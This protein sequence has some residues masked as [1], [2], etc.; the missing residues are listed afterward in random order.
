MLS[1]KD[2]RTR[3]CVIVKNTLGESQRWPD[4]AS[5]SHHLRALDFVEKLLHGLWP[6]LTPVSDAYPPA[7]VLRVFLKN[8]IFRS[9]STHRTLLTACYYLVLFKS[10]HN[11]MQTSGPSNKT[12]A[13][14]FL[15]SHERIFLSAFIL[16]WKFTQDYC[17]TTL[18]WASIS[19]FS[20]KDINA[21]EAYFL[22]TID[23]RLYI[24]RTE[25]EHW[26]SEVS[27][28]VRNPNAALSGSLLYPERPCAVL[29]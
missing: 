17:Y 6:S 21:S 13:F 8:V 11:E 27:Y 2:N 14:Q 29:I 12:R 25:F 15:Q 7:T 20:Q 23:W 26:Y 28:H 24:S 16:G 4:H 10:K 22:S 19:G 18:Q 3:Q 1:A 9:Q 5:G